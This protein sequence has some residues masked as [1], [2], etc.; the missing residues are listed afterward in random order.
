M[1]DPP[2]RLDIERHVA[3]PGALASETVALPKDAIASVGCAPSVPPLAVFRLLLSRYSRD[4]DT[5][6]VRFTDYLRTV[7][8]AARYSHGTGLHIDIG[9]GTARLTYDTDRFDPADMRRFVRHYRVLLAALLADPEQAVDTPSL[10][11][12]DE[13]RQVLAE[14]NA[15]ARKFSR[16]LRLPDLL[17]AA[18]AR[19]ARRT[20]L[21][22]RDRSLSYAEFGALVDGLATRLRRLG[23][24]PDTVVGLR[25]ER[26]VE[27]VVS[28]WAIMKAGGAYLP[29]DPGHPAARVEYLTENSGAGLVLTQPHLDRAGL[30]GVRVVDVEPDGAPHGGTTVAGSAGHLAY[31]IYTSG[32]TGRPKGVMVEHRAVVNRIEWM[33]REYRLTPGD[34]VLQKTPFGFDVSVWEFVWPLVTGARLVVAEPGGHQ[35]PLYLISLIRRT[36]ITTLHFVPS[37]LRLVLEQA[38]WADCTSV[39]QVFCSGEALPPELP[40]AHHAVHRAEL[41]NLYGPTEAAIDVSHWRCVPGQRTVPIGRPI[42]NIRLYVLDRGDRPQPI[43][44]VGELHIAGVGLARGYLGQPALTAER[45]VP[46][47]FA[48]SPGARMY[49]TGDLA[50]WLP[51]GTLEYAGRIDGQ[52]KLRGLRIEPGEIETHLA[53]HPAVRAAVV[54]V[55]EDVPGEPRLIGY[56]VVDRD[57]DLRAHL[58]TVLPDYL[59]PASIVALQELPVTANGKLDRKA[60]PAPIVDT[61]GDDDADDLSRAVARV[62]AD[63]LGLPAVAAGA[64][65]FALGGTSLAAGRACAR[66]ATDLARAVPVAWLLRDPTARGLA[67]CLRDTVAAPLFSVDAPIADVPLS[68]MQ[69]G[70]L[71]R[72]LL[73][74]QDRSAYC[75]GIWHIDGAVDTDALTTAVRYAHE[76]HQALRA[77]YVALRGSAVARVGHGPA[78]EVLVL[79][80]AASV[81]EAVA[82]LRRELGKPLDLGRSEVWRT[83]LVPLAGQAVLGY[84][85]H[86]IAYD[87]WSEA[88]L[89]ADLGAGYRGE[90]RADVPSLAEAWSVTTAH[91]QQADLDGQRAVLRSELTDVPALRFPAAD[92]NGTAPG[93]VERTLSPTDVAALDTMARELGVTRFVVLLAGYGHALARLIGQ[94][95]FGVGVPVARRVVSRLEQCVGCYI[96]MCCVRMRGAALAGDGAA[97][98]AAGTLVERALRTRDV[99]F[100]DVV[101]L[102]NPPRSARTPLFQNIFVYQDNASP[103]LDLGG[104]RATYLRQ[105]NLGLATEM[106]VDVWPLDSGGLRIVV[107][108]LPD[109]VPGHCAHDLA[110]R[111][112]TALRGFAGS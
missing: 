69:T 109:C 38:G 23:V 37:M 53:A 76:R 12:A 11:S 18:V 39:R 59:V 83:A 63:V 46:D 24:G 104:P 1:A 13:R 90:R 68:S 62:F 45:F 27:L 28:L 105:H 67:G 75:L 50:R 19:H 111:L 98:S 87:G 10:L 7:T 107:R 48:D 72:H 58:A 17:D 64:S 108:Y 81:G 26:S 88:V 44:C 106:Q 8:P 52:V 32:S 47:P 31:V 85:V 16:T 20:A 56:V 73:E 86:H 93:W 25:M 3:A 2:A 99:G 51:D 65:F 35:D 110:E 29:I 89:A 55:R 34:A 30:A 5:R 77:S 15:T 103:R 101:R 66:L 49:R 41:H 102:V 94:D 9:D 36:G 112:T 71:T 21:V 96:D 95:D 78:P 84:V 61:G 82:V 6:G 14:W 4:D 74:P 91:E 57:V 43:G 22:F 70:F 92:Q 100:G 97:V 40:A 79:P 42:Q 33:Q 60:L 80:A 54:V